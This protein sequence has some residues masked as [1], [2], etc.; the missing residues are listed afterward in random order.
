MDLKCEYS[1]RILS[2][3]EFDAFIFNLWETTPERSRDKSA[4]VEDAYHSMRGTTLWT[5]ALE[6]MASTH[7]FRGGHFAYDF[8][9]ARRIKWEQS[10]SGQRTAR[11][12]VGAE[13]K[14][15]AALSMPIKP[16]NV[17][18]TGCFPRLLAHVVS[19]KRLDS[20]ETIEWLLVFSAV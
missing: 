19:E 18:S 12:L 5:R 11:P 10:E 8:L 4:Q 13:S 15:L 16:W 7:E 1:R 6:S 20:I 17:F 9:W 3:D 2:Y 14:V